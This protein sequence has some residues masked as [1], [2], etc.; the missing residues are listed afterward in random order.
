MGKEII[1]KKVKKNQIF[2]NLYK[3]ENS[4]ETE[5][6]IFQELSIPSNKNNLNNTKYKN[7]TE[8][9]FKHKKSI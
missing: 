3:E 4:T 2:N 1:N 7:K 8:I 6:I 9:K 5:D